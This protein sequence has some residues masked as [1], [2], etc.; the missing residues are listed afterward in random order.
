[1]G[2]IT[3]IFQSRGKIPDTSEVLIMEVIVGKIAE[4]L[5][6]MTRIEI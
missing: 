2:V 5:S 1:M 6:L 3:A 4:R